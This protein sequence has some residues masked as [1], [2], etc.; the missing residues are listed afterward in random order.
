MG[1][2]NYAREWLEFA[3]R[4]LSSARFLLA[5]VPVPFEII[6]YLS[7]QS[8]EK[9]LKGLLVLHDMRP[10]KTHDLAELYRLCE[11]H[12]AGI[13][14]ILPSCHALNPYS[15]SPRYPHELFLNEKDTMEAL[16]AAEKVYGFSA[17]FFP[18]KPSDSVS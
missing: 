7:Q 17:V 18:D 10:L 8:A 6:C 15:V 4:D 13:E 5:Q 3:K 16:A 12:V 11:P 9:S 2:P 14:A 1:E